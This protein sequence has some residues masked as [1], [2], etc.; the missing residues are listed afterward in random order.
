MVA[1]YKCGT[2]CVV[3][4]MEPDSVMSIYSQCPNL[5]RLERK[6]KKLQGQKSGICTGFLLKNQSNKNPLEYDKVLLDRL[7]FLH[8]VFNAY[9]VLLNIT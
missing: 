5:I 9:L 8:D 4:A 1:V 7:K 3:D 2:G 6:T